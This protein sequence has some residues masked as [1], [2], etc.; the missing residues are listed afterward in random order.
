VNEN[1]SLNPRAILRFM[2][3]GFEELGRTRG[4]FTHHF[5]SFMGKAIRDGELSLKAKELM[6]L[7]MSLLTRCEYCIVWHTYH[8]LQAGA[9]PEEIYEAAE[10]AVSMGGGPTMTYAITWLQESLREFA[11]SDEDNFNGKKRKRAQYEE[12]PE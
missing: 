7:G 4:P 9:T 11:G 1:H 12:L 5:R 8:S 6:A 2:E 3:E 10:V